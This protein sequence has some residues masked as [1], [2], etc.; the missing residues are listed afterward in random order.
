VESE[1]LLFIRQKLKYIDAVRARND[2]Y[3]YDFA[4]IAGRHGSIKE[5]LRGDEMAELR[6]ARSSTSR[7]AYASPAPAAPSKPRKVQPATTDKAGWVSGAL[8]TKA[9]TNNICLSFQRGACRHAADHR[10]YRAA[11]ML[12]HLCVGCESAEHGYI[13]CPAK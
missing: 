1:R 12:R 7:A 5:S 13:N 8:E 2:T 9:R 4:D 3:L 10:A 11:S 6:A